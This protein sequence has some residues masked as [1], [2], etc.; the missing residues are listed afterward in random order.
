MKR[1]KKKE[2]LL[3]SIIPPS[4]LIG[5]SKITLNSN[6]EALIEG[7]R[8]IIEYEDHHIK[9]NLGNKTLLIVGTNLSIETITTS[10]VMIKGIISSMEF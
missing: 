5:E 8:N 6:K 4:A 7:C 2:H 9:L 3:S 1:E 10:G